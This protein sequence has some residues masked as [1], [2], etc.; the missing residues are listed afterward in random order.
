MT[1]SAQIIIIVTMIKTAAQSGFTFLEVMIAVAVIA[2]ALV[3]LIGSQS[4]SVT[5]ATQTRRNVTA[6]FLAQQKL[7]ELESTPFD[8][9]YTGSGDF[10]GD[11]SM[12]RWEAEVNILSADDT[13]IE[14]TDDILKTV[15]LAIFMGEND[16]QVYGVRTIVMKGM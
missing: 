3:T 11:I 14:G 1:I 4:Q 8:D 15:D 12:Y 13:G 7:A 9:L 2:I 5:V 16:Q 10:D 6:S